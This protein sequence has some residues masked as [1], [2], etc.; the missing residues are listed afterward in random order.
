MLRVKIDTDNDAFA[1]DGAGE[2]ARLLR[3]IA[4]RVAGGQMDGIVRDINGN[5]CGSFD[6]RLEQE[7]D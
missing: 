5:T 7:Q 4:E 6:L 2:V 3:N 1:G